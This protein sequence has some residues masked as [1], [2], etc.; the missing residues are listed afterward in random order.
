MKI[1]LLIFDFDGTLADT[2]ALIVTIKQEVMR[3]MGMKVES[4][5]VCAS[6]IGLP[7]EESYRAMYPTMPES[8]IAEC[9]DMYRKLFDEMKDSMPPT[10]FPGIRE[11]LAEI[12]RR[13]I[14]M[15][16]VTSRNSDSLNEFLNKWGIEGYFPYVLGGS[17]TAKNKPDPEPVLKTLSDLSYD[18]SE[19]LVVGD[20]PY[21][22]QMGKG[23]GAYTCG[24]TYG[25]SDRDALTAS[26][27]DY[28]IDRIG[29]LLDII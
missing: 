9:S 21:D 13:G 8:M 22:I 15:T 10:L 26:G 5:E 24:V 19:A 18:A 14:T 27:A 11:V 28:V 2:K 17:D 1:K 23:A 6:T 29:E 16:I 7:L 4:E 12:K 25:N 20:M 3:K